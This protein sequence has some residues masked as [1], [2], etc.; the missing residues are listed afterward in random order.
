MRNFLLLIVVF[1]FVSCQ[2]KKTEDEYALSKTKD[3]VNE[4]L[5]YFDLTLIEDVDV[6]DK[7]ESELYQVNNLK[8]KY[9]EDII[10]V[11]GFI[12]T[13]ACEYFKGNIE[14]KNDN[15]KLKMTNISK[16]LCMSNSKFE[17][18]FII[19]NENEKKYKINF[20]VK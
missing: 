10:Y 2:N 7:N 18:R 16:E 8:I 9:V 15:L 4:N 17:V 3:K 20:E 5:L 13:N 6:D 19:K 11:K 14:I 1:M 12:N